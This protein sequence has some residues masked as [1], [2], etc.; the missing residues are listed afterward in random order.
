[1]FKR[2]ENRSIVVRRL[3]AALRSTIQFMDTEELKNRI[4][5]H[6]KRAYALVPF[7]IEH[8]PPYHKPEHLT[9]NY[10]KKNW[11]NVCYALWMCRKKNNF[12]EE[13]VHELEAAQDY[14]RQLNQIYFHAAM[15]HMNDQDIKIVGECLH[16]LVHSPILSDADVQILSGSKREHFVAIAECWPDCDKDDFMLPSAVSG[17]LYM[18]LSYPHYKEAELSEWLSVPYS[19]AKEVCDKWFTVKESYQLKR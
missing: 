14:M 7:P 2:E 19:Q 17:A 11:R 12:S 5:E 18:L 4:E 3:R 8:L 10:E 16:A 1:M 6:V 15:Q 9:Q 13:I